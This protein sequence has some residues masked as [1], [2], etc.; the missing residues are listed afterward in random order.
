MTEPPR[1]PKRHPLTQL[2]IDAG[3][4]PDPGDEV[5]AAEPA[6]TELAPLLRDNRRA[7]AY[8]DA[9]LRD[10]VAGVAAT[11]SGSRNWALYQAACNL[12][13]FVEA[14]LLDRMAVRAALLAASRTNG[15]IPDDGL[16]A[17]EKTIASG[18]RTVEGKPREM[19]LADREW[20]S[21]PLIELADFGLTAPPGSGRAPT[22]PGGSPDGPGTDPPGGHP[23]DGSSPAAP[24][25]RYQITNQVGAGRW[26]TEE[27]GAR[28]L[29]GM[30]R[31]NDQ[32]VHTSRLGEDGYLE[33]A[34]KGDDNGPATLR[35][36][37]V[38]V[39]TA[40]LMWHYF[41]FKVVTVKPENKGDP[42][43]YFDQEIFFPPPAV[44]AA[45]ASIDEMT[46]LR[47]LRGVT[48]TPM[49]RRDGSI[50]DQPGY[51]VATGYLYLPTV[52]V[53]EVPE[54]P[55]R[56]QVLASVRLLR[57]MIDEFKWAGPHDEVNFLGL[58][59][60]PL[61]RELCPPPYK[62]AAVMARQPGSG[63]SLL[64]EI[65]RL[66]HG[67]VFRSEMPDDDTELGKSITGILSCT[68]APVVQFDN[69]GGTV[70]SSRLA[71]LLTSDV[72]SDRVLGSTNQLDM[73][74]DRLWV[75]TGNNMSFGGDLIRRTLWVTIDPGVPD[76]HL[77]TGFRIANLPLYV[78]EH[79]GEIIRSLL[80]LVRAWVVAGGRTE[81]RSSDSYARWSATVRG[82][83]SYVGVPGEFDHADSAQQSVGTDD[84]GWGE[85]LAAAF[86]AF[87]DRTFT[88][89]DLVDRMQGVERVEEIPTGGWARRVIVDDVARN[90][91]EALPVE[92]H[93]RYLRAQDPRVISK[94]LGR[95]FDKRT[96][97][98]AGSYVAE[99][100][101]RDRTNVLIWRVRALSGLLGS[102]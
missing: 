25:R 34:G 58:L 21:E 64:A 18:F 27:I 87:G 68:T 30:L 100:V 8:A 45:L 92:L 71:G 13:E 102:S 42:P 44:R 76:P 55:D 54:M 32:V 50:L 24:R 35:P 20:D 85:F 63:K 26:L 60:T 90:L 56:E 86:A 66:V 11:G 28:G 9:A 73:T 93:E 95:W 98:W 69:V 88:T 43:R 94:S 83:L 6:L 12:G 53:P 46:S 77:R 82:I 23:P 91:V 5:A 80:I 33:P 39:L 3:I 49:V 79:R 101:G 89:R 52:A 29:S 31:R 96:G 22:P 10:E 61:L 84:E 62:L 51:D 36:V 4:I 17:A 7:S 65:I 38:D 19:R 72:Y 78:T 75:I 97:R 59:L 67:G 81:L 57:S 74:N 16:A 14:G 41:V 99:K 1:R 47:M 48:H 70:R 15:Y 37:T 2:A 40:A